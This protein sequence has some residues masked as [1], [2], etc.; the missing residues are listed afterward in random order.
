MQIP[1]QNC[2]IYVILPLIK[3]YGYLEELVYSQDTASANKKSSE[4]IFSDLFLMFCIGTVSY[5]IAIHT[6]KQS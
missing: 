2:K 4:T 5:F 3:I 1:G 6:V